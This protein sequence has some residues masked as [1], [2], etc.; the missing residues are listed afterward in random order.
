MT[1]VTRAC[2]L[3]APVLL[4][5]CNRYVY[6][7][8]ECPPEPA[9]AL[10][11]TSAR[12]PT[13]PGTVAGVVVDSRAGRPVRAAVALHAT[14]ATAQA[15]HTARAPRGR[16]TD[17]AGAF[18]FDS[19]PPGRYALEVRAIG[20]ARRADSVAVTHG[21]GVVLRVPVKPMPFDDCPGFAV[22]V[23]RN[24]WWKLW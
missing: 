8:P 19:V 13:G 23:T 14:A 10:R 11:V 18:R 4:A 17:S 20:F 24:P 15:A 2:V 5:A 1:L 22:V 6:T 12:A 7:E 21:A 3:V 9:A 16:M